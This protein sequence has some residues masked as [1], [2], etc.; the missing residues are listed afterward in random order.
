MVRVGQGAGSA[1]PVLMLLAAML[2]VDGRVRQ[3]LRAADE[4]PTAPSA[5]T[6]IRPPVVA[7]AVSAVTGDVVSASQA[8]LNARN[9]RTA[10][11]HPHDVE[12][13]PNGRQLL[14]SGGQPGD[15]GLLE[16]FAWPPA[17]RLTPHTVLRVGEDSLYAAAWSPAGDVVAVAGLDGTGRLLKVPS[18]EEIVRLEGHSQGLTGITFVTPSRVVTSSRDGSVRVWDAVRGELI[19]TLA[20]HTGPVMGLRRGPGSGPEARRMIVSYGED[21]TVRLWQPLIGRMVRF[22]RLASRPLAVEWIADGPLPEDSGGMLAIGCR[23]GVVR[24]VSVDTV[25]V[26]TERKVLN[27]P[28]YCMAFAAARDRLYAAG[29][30]GQ[31]VSI[32]LASLLSDGPG[33]K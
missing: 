19:R 26:H 23:D 30:D 7:L 1:F 3:M 15:Q 33:G 9:L 24:L 16:L 29:H 22:A 14:L 10:V 17:D 2:S 8:G 18:G 32:E 5:E 31:V 12:F 6:P 13:S 21:R 11:P 28:V 27:G 20:N 4:Q 25:Q